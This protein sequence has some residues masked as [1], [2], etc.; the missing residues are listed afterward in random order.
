MLFN[1]I[2]LLDTIISVVSGTIAYLLIY[3]TN[4]FVYSTFVL[5]RLYLRQM[6]EECIALLHMCSTSQAKVL[7]SVL[8]FYLKPS[9][10]SSHVS[11]AVA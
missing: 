5:A 10:S 6:I 2:L 4:T 7:Y 8:L 1:N 9:I 3:S 11:A